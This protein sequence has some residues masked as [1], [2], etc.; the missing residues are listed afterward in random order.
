MNTFDRASVSTGFW[1]LSQ[2]LGF[3]EKHLSSHGTDGERNTKWLN[4]LG[5]VEARSALF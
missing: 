5:P 2:R 3:P 4:P 1:L